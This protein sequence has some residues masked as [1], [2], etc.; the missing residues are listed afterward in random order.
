MATFKPLYVKLVNDSEDSI[1]IGA[2]IQLVNAQLPMSQHYSLEEVKMAIM[3]LA[4][5]ETQFM[6]DSEGETLLFL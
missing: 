3:R 4:A 1:F 6:Y 2:L 5:A